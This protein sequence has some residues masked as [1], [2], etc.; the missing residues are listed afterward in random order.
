MIHDKLVTAALRA[1]LTEASALLLTTSDRSDQLTMI[2]EARNTAQAI[3]DLNLDVGHL[4]RSY[5]K[6]PTVL[7]RKTD[8]LVERVDCQ[9]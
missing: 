7:P 1:V 9:K 8:Q 5:I 2:N 6:S 3:A 4:Q